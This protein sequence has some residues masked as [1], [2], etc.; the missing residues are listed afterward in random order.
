MNYC[1]FT[2]PSQNYLKAQEKKAVLCTA[3][4][5]F[6]YNLQRMAVHTCSRKNQSSFE[7]LESTNGDKNGANNDPSS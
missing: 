2:I 1:E 5:R 6:I 7:D 3:S 4:T